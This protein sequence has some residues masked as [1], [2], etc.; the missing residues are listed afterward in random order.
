MAHIFVEHRKLVKGVA[1]TWD[2]SHHL[3]IRY[4]NGPVVIV[5]ENPLVLLAALR[6]QWLK[7]IMK[8]RNEYSRTLNQERKRELERI[9]GEMESLHFVTSL[10]A[11]AAH[12]PEICI[13]KPAEIDQLTTTHLTIYTIGIQP[14]REI[15]KQH[16]LRHGALIEYLMDGEED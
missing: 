16:I 4:M 7:V 3:Y 2:L 15:L 12:E 6:K 1:L 9:I 10:P 14:K 11:P 5:V 8:L 13:I